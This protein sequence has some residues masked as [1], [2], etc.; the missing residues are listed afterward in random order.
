IAPNLS[1]CGEPFA[2][3]GRPMGVA[4]DSVRPLSPRLP[5]RVVLADRGGASFVSANDR[6]CIGSRGEVRHE[7]SIGARRYFSGEKIMRHVL[8]AALSAVSVLAGFEQAFAAD[9]EW[10]VDSPFR[11]YKVG[12]SFAV[13]EKAF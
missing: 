13:H 2:N 12:S 9:L 10:E 8:M 7:R 6:G 3:A 1:R 4:P 11:F 5:N